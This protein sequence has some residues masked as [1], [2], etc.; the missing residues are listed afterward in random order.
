MRSYFHLYEESVKEDVMTHTIRSRFCIVRFIRTRCCKIKWKNV[1]LN[2][3]ED[4]KIYHNR[5]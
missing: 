5:V 3:K 1:G 4:M 2:G